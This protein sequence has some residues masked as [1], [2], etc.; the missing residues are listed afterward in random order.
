MKQNNGI[1]KSSLATKNLRDY[2]IGTT[3]LSNW[4]VHKFNNLIVTIGGTNQSLFNYV[5]YTEEAEFCIKSVQE[6]LNYLQERKIEATWPIDSH[7]KVRTKLENLGIK[8]AS[9]PKKAFLNIRGHLPFHGRAP[10]LVLKV[11]NSQEDLIELDKMTSVIFYH[12]IGIVSTFLRGIL[13]HDNQASKLKFFLAK[14][15]GK[16]VGTC[17]IYIE[18]EIAGFYSDGVLPMYRNQGIATEMIMQR[19]KIAQQ[20]CCKYVIAH[21]MKSSVNLYKRVGF[22]MLGNLHLYISS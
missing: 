2:I 9:T 10:N 14:L 18:D 6:V 12:D 11:V 16:T 17:G 19:I 7:M 22:K 8:S 20:Y 21:C 13:N 4:E 5:F 1:L 15:N 3:K